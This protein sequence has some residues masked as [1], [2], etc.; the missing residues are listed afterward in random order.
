M[1]R[2]KFLCAGMNPG[3]RRTSVLFVYEG[4]LYAGPCLTV[5]ARFSGEPITRAPRRGRPSTLRQRF[6]LLRALATQSLMP[7]GS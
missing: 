3:Q 2:R 7:L 1:S 6:G 5:S 4:H